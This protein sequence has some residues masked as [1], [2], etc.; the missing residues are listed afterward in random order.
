[1]TN[2][3]KSAREA[4]QERQWKQMQAL[5]H[6]QNQQQQHVLQEHRV[7]GTNCKY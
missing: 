6:Q 1:M 4:E 7:Q 3:Q 5:R 2:Q